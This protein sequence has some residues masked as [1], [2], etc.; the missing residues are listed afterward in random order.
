[1]QKD[2]VL[3]LTRKER[4]EDAR[5]VHNQHGFQSTQAVIAATK[6][7]SATINGGDIVALKEDKDFV[8]V[9]NY[10]G[11]TLTVNGGT[12]EAQTAAICNL[13]DVYM[14]GGTV[15]SAKRIAVVEGKNST[16]ELNDGVIKTD[17]DD[18]AVTLADSGAKFAMNGG[19]RTHVAVPA[20]RS[21]G[22]RN[23]L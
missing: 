6:V 5:T 18:Q 17:S 14:N 3:P 11:S 4:F 1:M 19:K 2:S 7:S 16:F 20:S 8:A 10:A 9:Y 12:I 22:I 21:S 23:L 15:Y 13:G